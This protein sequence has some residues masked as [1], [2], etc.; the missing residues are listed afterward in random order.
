MYKLNKFLEQLFDTIYFD[1]NE[2]KTAVELDRSEAHEHRE[3]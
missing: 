1:N 2:K 3:Y